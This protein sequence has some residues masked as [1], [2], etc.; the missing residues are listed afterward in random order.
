MRK[1]HANFEYEEKSG[2]EVRRRRE[3]D[4]G[5]NIE[6]IEDYNCSCI[7]SRISNASTTKFGIKVPLPR[8]SV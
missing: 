7:N 1:L 8:T 4:G 3:R 2:R 5:L 6:R